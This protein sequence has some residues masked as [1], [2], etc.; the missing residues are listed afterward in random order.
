[1][2]HILKTHPQPFDDVFRGIKTFEF[3]L[4]DRNYQVG[5][6]LVLRKYDPDNSEFFFHEDRSYVEEYVRVN[7]IIRGPAYGIPEG[8]ACMSISK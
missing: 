8:Y 6:I 4:D 2:L 5:D 1:M 3:R 7:H